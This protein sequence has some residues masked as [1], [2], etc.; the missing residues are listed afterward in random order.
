MTY[1]CSILKRITSSIR[2]QLAP[3]V[4]EETGEDQKGQGNAEVHK[5]LEKF[6][7]QVLHT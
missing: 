1:Y 4:L 2:G 5:A 6:L 7:A 3:S